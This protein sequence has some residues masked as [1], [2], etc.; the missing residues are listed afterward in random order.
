MSLIYTSVTPVL[1]P[2]IYSLRNKEVE[3]ALKRLLESHDQTRPAVQCKGSGKRGSTCQSPVGHVRAALAAP[4]LLLRA[5]LWFC[6]R[7]DLTAPFPAVT[8]GTN[9]DAFRDGA[10]LGGVS[11]R[12][13]APSRTM[14]PRLWSTVRHFS[15]QRARSTRSELPSPNEVKARGQ[16]QSQP[17]GCNP[18]HPPPARPPL[19]RVS[20]PTPLPASGPAGP[21][22]CCHGFEGRS[23]L[24]ALGRARAL[25]HYLGLKGFALFLTGREAPCRQEL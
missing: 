25:T 22:S 19:R 8:R 23:L 13:T 15:G 4:R 1:H 14:T 2:M 10:A 18:L 16:R 5:A 12:F 24:A 9:P 20:R 11:E 7:L 3:G 21:S 6:G 17:R